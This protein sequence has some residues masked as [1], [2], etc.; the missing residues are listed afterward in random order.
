MGQV[1]YRG[2]WRARATPVIAG[3]LSATDGMSDK[4]IRRALREAYPFCERKWWPYK[5][6]CDEVRKQRK[7]FS[8]V[9]DNQLLLFGDI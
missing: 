1:S 6:W 7:I 3:V 5:V 9:P 2:T 8:E 4:E